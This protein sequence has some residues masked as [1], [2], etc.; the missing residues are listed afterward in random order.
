MENINLKLERSTIDDKDVLKNL[1][2]YYAHDLSEFNDSLKTDPN[3]LFGN[4]IDLYFNDGRLIPL[5]IILENSI[6][7]FLFCSKGQTVDY[8]IQD[9]FILR[10]YRNRGLGKLALKQLFSLYPGK[11]GLDIL[12]KNT[13]AKL[14]WT[15]CLE[16]LGINYTSSELISDGQLGTRLFFNSRKS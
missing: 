2:L 7:G 10:N 3:G 16:H 9:M 6:I 11:F 8:V 13:P 1:Y 14:F 4:S 12:I 15:H 5:K